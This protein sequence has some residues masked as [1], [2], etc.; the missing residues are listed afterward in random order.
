MN[1]VLVLSEMKLLSLGWSWLVI[2][3][4][5][6]TIVLAWLLGPRLARKS[7]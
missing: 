7:A 1:L 6:G 5:A 4:T 2:W 3:G